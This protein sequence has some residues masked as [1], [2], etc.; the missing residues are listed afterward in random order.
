M[1]PRALVDIDGVLRDFITGGLPL[2]ERITGR[3]HQHDDVDQWAMEKALGLT[4]EESKIFYTIVSGEHFAYELP[5]YSGAVEAI[6]KLREHCEVI[7]VTAHFPGSKTWVHDTDRWLAKHFASDGHDVIHTNAKH[8]VSGD[9][10]IEDKTS[11]LLKWREDPRGHALPLR[12]GM[13][14]LRNYNRREVY[15]SSFET[16]DDIVDAIH[17]SI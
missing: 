11:T 14:L 3:V 1:T 8:A 2:V 16:L 12:R 5:V 9:F 10:L 7:F 13:R 15:G 17:L 4:D 6:A